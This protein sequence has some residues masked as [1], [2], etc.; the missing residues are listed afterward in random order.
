MTVRKVNMAEKAEKARKAKEAEKA[1]DLTK[2]ALDYISQLEQEGDSNLHYA[3]LFLGKALN[4]IEVSWNSITATATKLVIGGRKTTITVM[5]AGRVLDIR[6]T[7][8]EY[9]HVVAYTDN[10]TN[11]VTLFYTSRADLADRHHWWVSGREFTKSIIE[12]VKG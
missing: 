5:R 7:L 2:A 9:S 3:V 8:R 1:W 10:K 12:I 4:E 6:T 11:D